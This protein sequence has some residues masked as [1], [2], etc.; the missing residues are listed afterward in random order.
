MTVSLLDAAASY[1]ILKIGGYI[2]GSLWPYMQQH[3]AGAP[4][5]EGYIQE[6]GHIPGWKVR[7]VLID[8]PSTVLL[9]LASLAAATFAEP[10]DYR[11]RLAVGLVCTFV[12]VRAPIWAPGLAAQL[13]RR[14][15]GSGPGRKPVQ[16]EAAPGEWVR[17]SLSSW[18]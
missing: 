1:R 17:G 2:R 7:A 11:L 3:G 12:T 18:R 9:A 8:G 16:D 5:W 15:D 14:R 4:S 10:F 6:L 13:V